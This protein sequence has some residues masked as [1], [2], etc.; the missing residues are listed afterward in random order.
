MSRS[1]HTWRTCTRIHVWGFV[2]HGCARCVLT[3]WV[4]WSNELANEMVKR[5]I[6]TLPSL[7][8]DRSLIRASHCAIGAD[9][10]IN[11][12]CSFQWSTIIALLQPETKKEH[13]LPLREQ[14]NASA[15]VALPPRIPF[16]HILSLW[17][18]SKKLLHQLV[19]LSSSLCS[20]TSAKTLSFALP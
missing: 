8:V 15:L 6:K 18:S 12:I 3:V 16:L 9:V 1:P 20:S 19:Q 13:K 4:R 10:D 5:R 11:T 2:F 14:V 17:G 7:P